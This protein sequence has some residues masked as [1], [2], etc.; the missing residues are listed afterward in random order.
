MTNRRDHGDGAIDQRGKDRWRQ[1]YWVAG[2]SEAS[3]LILGKRTGGQF[4]A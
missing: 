4:H 3:R 2:I 1:R